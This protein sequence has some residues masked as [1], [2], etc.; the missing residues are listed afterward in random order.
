MLVQK[1]KR[2]HHCKYILLQESYS[3][4]KKLNI[5]GNLQWKNCLD[6]VENEFDWLKNAKQSFWLLFDFFLPIKCLSYIFCAKMLWAF[7]QLQLSIKSPRTIFMIVKI[8][9]SWTNLTGAGVTFDWL[10]FDNSKLIDF[11][12]KN[13]SFLRKKFIL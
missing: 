6:R 7:F 8:V 13:V 11:D 10:F 12:D 1:Q 3:D 5:T 2:H 4:K 9:F